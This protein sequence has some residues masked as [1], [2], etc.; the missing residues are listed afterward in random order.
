MR[1]QSPAWSPDGR[2]I[3][4]IGATSKGTDVFTAGVDGKGV[5]R[6]TTTGQEQAPQWSPNGRLLAFIDTT[7]NAQ[8]GEIAVIRADGTGRRLLTHGA[9][10]LGVLSWRCG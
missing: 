9:G 8:V 6:L 5:K 10:A 7:A 1:E 4:Y 3:A 2:R